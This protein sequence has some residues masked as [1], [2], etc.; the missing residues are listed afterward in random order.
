[1]S[2]SPPLWRHPDFVKLWG[3]RTISQP[4]SSI[5]RDALPFIAVI[6]L[7]ASPA[8]VGVLGAM[9]AVLGVLIVSGGAG[10]LIGSLINERAV[11]RLGVERLLL[12]SLLFT[13]LLGWLTPLAGGSAWLNFT[14][15]LY[16]QVFGDLA[17][18]IYSINAL[19]LQQGITPCSSRPSPAGKPCH[20]K[21][22]ERIRQRIVQ[23]DKR[24]NLYT[25]KPLAL[26]NASG[27][28]PCLHTSPRWIKAPQARAA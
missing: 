10:S 23:Q 25:S 12:F 4:G 8:Q 27:A 9:E 20:R 28:I 15:L 26:I 14:M 22:H 17:R 7:S 21:R 16:G 18:T 11:R 13:T 24:Y 6:T 2:P 3:G 5:T 19:S 1:M